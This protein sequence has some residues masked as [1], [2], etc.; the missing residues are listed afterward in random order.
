VLLWQ[1]EDGVIYNVHDD[2]G[3]NSGEAHG[4]HRDDLPNKERNQY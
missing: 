3:I 4:Q 1:E 2:F